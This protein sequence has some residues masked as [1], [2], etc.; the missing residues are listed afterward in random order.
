MGLC[1]STEG[2]LKRGTAGNGKK[3]EPPCPTVFE[4]ERIIDA[5]RGAATRLHV[6]LVNIEFRRG[7]FEVYRAGCSSDS[8]SDEDEDDVD[9]GG[10]GS[11]RGGAGSGAGSG[12]GVGEPVDSMAMT[13]SHGAAA[14]AAPSAETGRGRSNGA[15]GDVFVVTHK[16]TGPFWG[17]RRC[18]P[19]PSPRFAA[20]KNRKRRPGPTKKNPEEEG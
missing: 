5:K 20:T 17:G 15:R 8:D 12:A 7:L 1:Q 10:G 3:V 16:V 9:C 4:L 19:S 2:P 11:A 6:N 14:L 18:R 13:G